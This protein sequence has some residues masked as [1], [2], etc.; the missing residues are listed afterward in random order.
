MFAH[1]SPA[2]ET[3]AGSS[4]GRSLAASDIQL[5]FS[6]A[7]RALA[8]WPRGAPAPA[9][10]SQ[11]KR[12]DALRLARS[13]AYRTLRAFQAEQNRCLISDE[14]MQRAL[15]HPD[16]MICGISLIPAHR[17]RSALD[18]LMAELKRREREIRERIAVD[19]GRYLP[20]RTAWTPVR[21]WVVISSQWS[22]DA[23]T[24]SQAG[25]GPASV[26]VN[27]T[28][29]LSYAGTAKERVDA[30]EHVLAHE[31]FHVGVRQF[32]DGSP[33]WAD[34]GARARSASA[35]VARVLLDEGV[36]HYVDWRTRPGSDTLFTKVPGPREK[37]AFSQLAL[38]AKRL[39][40]PLEG[41]ARAEI[42]Q[43]AS[44]G[45]LWSKYGSVSGM[46]AAFRIESRLG[47]DSLRAAVV[48]GPREFLR[49]YE[50]V[51]ASD[52]SLGR[53]PAEFVRGD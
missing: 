32:E 48:G 26:L 34:F 47:A 19:A 20:P 2:R 27:A 31:T 25:H 39:G 16:S 45:P 50:S 14:E 29:V 49:M 3:R 6:P 23:A 44:T 17:Q 22:F 30:L 1:E 38:A 36:A 28:E 43:L 21:V 8:L 9:S 12:R 7:V 11:A 33:G 51:A 52:T 4:G 18:S 40:Q 15:L 53:V 41:G 10:Y 37:K 24:L 46:F 5:D 42:L 13:D 35:H